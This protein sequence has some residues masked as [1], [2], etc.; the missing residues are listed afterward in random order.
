MTF[1]GRSRFRDRLRSVGGEAFPLDGITAPN[2]AYAT[3][4]LSAANFSLP[5]ARFRDEGGAGEVNVFDDGTGN[6]SDAS[7]TGASR[8][9]TPLGTWRTAGQAQSIRWLY[10]QGAYGTGGA[11]D[12]GN[13]TGTSQPTIYNSTGVRETIGT[14]NLATVRGVNVAGATSV[15]LSSGSLTATDIAGSLTDTTIILIHRVPTAGTTGSGPHHAGGGVDM[16]LPFSTGDY[17]F[18]VG[19]G[20]SGRVTGALTNREVAAVYAGWRQGVNINLLRN[21]VSLNSNSSAGAGVTPGV[22]ILNLFNTVGDSFCAARLQW[23]TKISDAE[24]ALVTSR[25]MAKL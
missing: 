25:L 20:G 21:G 11:G 22:A 18:D 7:P 10:N 23:N 13:A 24:I 6:I 15:T 2:F 3:F 16:Y 8:S 9:G 1:L 5:I 17:F 14:K 19:T 12:V 4:A